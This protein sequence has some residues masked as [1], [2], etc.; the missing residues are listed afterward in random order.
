MLVHA[1]PI[2]IH[3]WNTKRERAWYPFTD[4]SFKETEGALKLFGP[5]IPNS[6]A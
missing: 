3:R 2:L 6:L 1:L 4:K 5:R